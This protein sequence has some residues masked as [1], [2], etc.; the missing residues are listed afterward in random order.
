MADNAAENIKAFNIEGFRDDQEL[1]YDD[2]DDDEELD[3]H[4]DTDEMP[5]EDNEE[6]P[7]ASEIQDVD[8]ED[9][10]LLETELRAES[11]WKDATFQRLG[12]LAHALQL[13]I[14]EAL[15]SNKLAKDLIQNVSEMV[16]FFHKSNT[17]TEKLYRKTKLHVVPVG[18]TRWNTVSIALERMLSVRKR[19]QNCLLNFFL[20][21]YNLG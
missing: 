17:W 1:R 3:E 4:D 20:Q 14:K 7:C 9:E 15:N 8:Q 16:S 6:L 2:E 10:H 19:S 13:V 18:K 5:Q 12:C 11:D 21:Y